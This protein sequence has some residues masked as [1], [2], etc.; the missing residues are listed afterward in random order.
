MESEGYLYYADEPELN[1]C[2]YDADKP[3]LNGWLKF[4]K[5]ITDIEV[6]APDVKVFNMSFDFYPLTV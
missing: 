4:L 3:E 5:D 6:L 1:G 2:L